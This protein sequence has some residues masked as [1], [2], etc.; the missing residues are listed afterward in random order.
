MQTGG[1]IRTITVIISGLPNFKNFYGNKALTNSIDP[2]ETAPKDQSDQ[3]CTVCSGCSNPIF[4]VNMIIYIFQAFTII[5]VLNSLRFSLGVLPFAVKSLADAK[6]SFKRYKVCNT[7]T[8]I[9]TILLAWFKL[10][11]VMCSKTKS[12][13]ER[14]RSYTCLF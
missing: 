7:L 6:V 12:M 1:N 4:R 3:G 5:A 10:S 14:K 13:K 8:M 9:N 11:P 2:D